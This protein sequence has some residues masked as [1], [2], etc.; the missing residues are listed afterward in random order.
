M[1]RKGRY[2]KLDW[3]VAT[4]LKIN[5]N[6]QGIFRNCLYRLLFCPGIE[7][8][9]S[10]KY[11]VASSFENFLGSN[12]PLLVET[13]RANRRTRKRET[14]RTRTQE[15]RYATQRGTEAEVRLEERRSE[16]RR[17][18]WIERGGGKK[19]RKETGA[20]FFKARVTLRIVRES[21]VSPPM[22]Y[23]ILSAP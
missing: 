11:H 19:R 21:V 16:K 14:R 15:G 8:F 3:I 17:E 6:S 22:F 13:T 1:K 2:T 23:F 18:K 10:Q 12:I 5:S 4:G 20:P 9:E 7:S